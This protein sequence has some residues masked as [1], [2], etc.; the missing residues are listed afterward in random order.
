MTA[1]A[2]LAVLVQWAALW[3]LG[4]RLSRAMGNPAAWPL[5]LIMGGVLGVIIKG[6]FWLFILTVAFLIG[7]GCGSDVKPPSQD[8]KYTPPTE[9]KDAKAKTSRGPGG[10]MMKSKSAR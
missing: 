10:G 9:A 7:Q 3:A 5:P 2:V 1:V 6:A 8:D 4:K